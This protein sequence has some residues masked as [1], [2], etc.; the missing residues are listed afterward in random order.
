MYSL[1]QLTVQLRDLGKSFPEPRFFIHKICGHYTIFQGSSWFF[2]S[3]PC[4][5]ACGIFVSSPEIEPVPSALVAWSV[6]HWTTREV[7]GF[8][9]A[10]IF[11]DNLTVFRWEVETVVYMLNPYLFQFCSQRICL[12]PVY[13]NNLLINVHIYFLGFNILFSYNFICMYLVWLC[14][15]FTAAREL[16]SSCGVRAFHLRGFSCCRAQ[17]LG[18]TDF[19]NHS[20][21]A[22]Q[23]WL[24]GS[25]AQAQCFWCTGLV[26]PQRVVYSWIRDQT[27][28]S[29]IGRE[30]LS[31]QESPVLFSLL[32]IK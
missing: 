18:R 25:R 30:I 6:N 14:W 16:C 11:C 10:L 32:I 15:V 2:S 5:M 28:V 20:A 23:S 3:W 9:L 27:R 21:W 8:L 17:A 19:S 31:H 1:W 4:R 24:P 22:R 26:A 13:Y 29:C 12:E 7:S